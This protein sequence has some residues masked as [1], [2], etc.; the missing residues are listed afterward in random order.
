MHTRTPN[1]RECSKR[2]AARSIRNPDIEDKEGRFSTRNSKTTEKERR[3]TQNAARP[4]LPIVQLQHPLKKASCPSWNVGVPGSADESS[5]QR[6]EKKEGA[7]CLSYGH[8]FLG[9]SKHLQRENKRCVQRAA[10]NSWLSLQ[11]LLSAC[12]LPGLAFQLPQPVRGPKQLWTQCWENQPRA[13]QKQTRIGSGMRPPA[14]ITHT[15][16]L[17]LSSSP[18]GVP[19]QAHRV[20]LPSLLKTLMVPVWSI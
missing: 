3:E 4:A 14:H 12:T 11:G 5:G 15:H 6:R 18:S 2:N 13:S 10:Q 17:A 7:A 8:Y 1:P 20:F 16:S 9:K 19:G